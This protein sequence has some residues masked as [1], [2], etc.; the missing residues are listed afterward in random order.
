MSAT[1]F[2]DVRETMTV[3]IDRSALPTVTIKPPT[4]RSSL[5]LREYLPHRYL[6][7]QLTRREVVLRFRQTLLG[8]SWVV[9]QPLLTAGVLTAV[10]AWVRATNPTFDTFVVALWAAIGWGMFTGCVSRG[11]VS[12]VNNA[13]LVRKVH[14]PRALL[15]MSSCL[16]VVVDTLVS[17][18]A[19]LV[20]L[21]IGGGPF[22]LR[23]LVVI[24]ALFGIFLLGTGIAVGASGISAKYR[25]V[26]YAIPFLLQVLV[27][28]SPVAY[29]LGSFEGRARSL[30]LANPLTGWLLLLR[31]AA[32]TESVPGRAV[33]WSVIATAIAVCGGLVAFVR[34]DRSMSDL[35]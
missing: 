6:L 10:F 33:V 21:A 35:L 26:Q 34:S 25:D 7:W 28:A 5:D 16:A 13:N 19:A 22:T 32:G 29:G 31:S 24:P 27:F 11:S 8:A 1:G 9:L 14:F 20:A 15:P 2:T 12:I 4:W 30:L 23:L 18:I 17:L 3:L